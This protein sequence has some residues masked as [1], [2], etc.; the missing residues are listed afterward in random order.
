[1]VYMCV[2]MC[3]LMCGCTCV[4]LCVDV[5]VCKC[6][7]MCV[8]VCM[9]DYT[10]HKIQTLTCSQV[11]NKASVVS[12]RELFQA[13]VGSPPAPLKSP[14]PPVPPTAIA[15]DAPVKS[16]V[17]SPLKSLVNISLSSP[18]SAVPPVEEESE[19]TEEGEDPKSTAAR[20]SQVVRVDD[21]ISMDSS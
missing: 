13:E 9:R 4:C 17:K 5:C 1:M 12:A 21:L 6:G 11:F 20:R 18:A 3:V 10:I 2:F 14:S 16:P 7:C 15:A 19:D 8:R